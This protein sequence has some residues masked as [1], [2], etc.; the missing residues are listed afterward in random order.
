V[1]KLQAEIEPG[2]FCGLALDE[3][4]QD[5]LTEGRVK[6]WT[7]QVLQEMGVKATAAA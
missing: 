6:Q 2:F 1:C 5:D 4:N 3:D 7:A